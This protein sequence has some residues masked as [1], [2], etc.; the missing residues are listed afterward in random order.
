VMIF[1]PVTTLEMIRI[2]EFILSSKGYPGRPIEDRAAIAR[3]F[4]ASKKGL[5]TTR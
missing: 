2:E 5:A 3:A 4:V 1:S